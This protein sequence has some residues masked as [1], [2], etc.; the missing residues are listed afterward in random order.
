MG[1]EW[2]STEIPDVLRGKPFVASD[3]RGV[4]V[5]LWQRPTTAVE[6]IPDEVFFSTSASGAVRGMHV[7][8]GVRQGHRLVFVTAGSARDFVID[9]RRG[10]PMYG[11]VVE[12]RLE[13]SGPAVLIPPGC[14]H[15]FE[16]LADGTTMVYAQ[17][18][19]HDPALDIGVH[20][21]SCG[22]TPQ[23]RFPIVSERD[24]SLPRLVDFESPFRWVERD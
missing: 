8:S 18:G 12:T 5:K 13:P 14:A 9:L 23:S 2:T 20:W 22:I 1:I 10:S 11:V 24:N 15:G 4:F 6:L 7:Q 16:S 17:H 3:S 19:V 21:A